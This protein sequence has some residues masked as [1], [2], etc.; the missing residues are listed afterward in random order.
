MKALCDG[1]LLSARTASGYGGVAAASCELDGQAV[2][3]VYGHI[4]LSSITFKIG[5]Q[6]KAG[7]F[8]A[9]LGTGFSNE[10]DGERKHLHLGIHKGANINILGYVQNKNQLDD[11]IDPS[12]YLQ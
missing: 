12:K 3:V 4:K 8:L 11:W 9:N 10:T 2:T 5:D 7:D 1:K 6:M